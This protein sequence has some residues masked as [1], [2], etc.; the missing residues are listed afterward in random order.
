MKNAEGGVASEAKPVRAQ[1]SLS[2]LLFEL[3]SR[4]PS[5]LKEQL[6]QAC[7]CPHRLRFARHL[8]RSAGAGPFPRHSS[9]FSQLHRPPTSS[10]KQ[11]GAGR[12]I[13]LVHRPKRKGRDVHGC[14]W[15]TTRRAASDDRPDP[16]T[17]DGPA[18]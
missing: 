2:Q 4:K 12:A 14:P 13:T 3:E 7:L 6:G 18:V 5:V 16:P 15:K 8:S 9:V 17:W 10:Y 1:A 11:T